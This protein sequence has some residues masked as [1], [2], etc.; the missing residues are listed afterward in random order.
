MDY[1]VLPLSVFFIFVAPL[2]LVLHYRSRKQT[3]K[4]FSEKDQK[5]LQELLT[6]TEQ[7]QKRITSLEKLLDA[8]NPKWRE[9]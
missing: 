3:S 6:R 9:K 7:M 1:I 2:W 8:E 4:G 5:R